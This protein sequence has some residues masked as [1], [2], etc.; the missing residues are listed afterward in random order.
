[1]D[2]GS[3]VMWPC[4]MLTLYWDITEHP[5]LKNVK[6]SKVLIYH[7]I[8][9]SAFIIILNFNKFNLNN[10]WKWQIHEN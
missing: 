6:Y 7:L 8:I 2:E 3:I 4:Q 5:W 10:N 1:M 9:Y